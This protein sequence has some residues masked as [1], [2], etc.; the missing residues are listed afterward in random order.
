MKESENKMSA[1]VIALDLEKDVTR[2][3]R[4]LRRQ[5]PT[6][7]EMPIFVRATDE[8]HRRKLASA[9]AIALDTGPQESA[10]LLGGALL[11]RLGFPQD[12]VARL[13]ED[14]RSSLYKKKMKTLMGDLEPGPLTKPFSK[15]SNA[16]SKEEAVDLNAQLEKAIDVDANPSSTTS[17]E[18]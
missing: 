11:S 4:A 18:Q 10:L 12:E 9:G 3:V 17:E 7:K 8:K 1:V 13:I 14:T 6:V 16:E 15:S 5:F 2:A